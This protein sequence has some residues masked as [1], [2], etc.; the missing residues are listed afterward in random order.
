METIVA[1][2]RIRRDLKF[3]RQASTKYLIKPCNQAVYSAYHLGN[4]VCE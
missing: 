4:C 3:E 1:E 2:K